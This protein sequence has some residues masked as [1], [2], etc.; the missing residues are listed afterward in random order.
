MKH[1]FTKQ[2]GVALIAVY[3][4]ICAAYGVFAQT[5]SSSKKSSPAAFSNIKLEYQV[6]M[7]DAGWLGWT[8]GGMMSG[9]LERDLKADALQVKLS[10]QPSGGVWYAVCTEDGVWQAWT[11]NGEVSGKQNQANIQAIALR[12][13]DMP[14]M[15]IEYRVHVTG[16]EWLAWTSNGEVAGSIGKGKTID[17]VEIRLQNN[18]APE[19]SLLG[20]NPPPTPGTASQ[21]VP[22]VVTSSKKKSSSAS[23]DAAS[24]QP[25]PAQGVESFTIKEPPPTPPTTTSK[26]TSAQ[27]S[28]AQQTQAQANQAQVAP[29]TSNQA[30]S[31]QQQGNQT[32]WGG[33]ANTAGQLAGQAMSGMNTGMANNNFNRNNTQFSQGNQ[34]NQA[35]NSQNWSEWTNQPMQ[36]V[37]GQGQSAEQP[38]FVPISSRRVALV[39]NNNRYLSAMND[40]RSDAL[41]VANRSGISDTEIFE[42]AFLGEHRVALKTVNGRYLSVRPMNAGSSTITPS[43]DIIGTNETF[44]MLGS[45]VNDRVTFRAF[46]GQFLSVEE[47]GQFRLFAKSGFAGAAESFSIFLPDGRPILSEGQ[48]QAGSWQSQRDANGRM[49]YLDGQGRTVETSDRVLLLVASPQNA[50]STQAMNT[51]S[52]TS[53]PTNALPTNTAP[54]NTTP[55]NSTATTPATPAAKP[56]V[57]PK[58]YLAPIELDVVQEINFVRTKPGEY[59]TLLEG[60]RK[61][62][63]GRTLSVPGQRPLSTKE[64]VKALDEAILALK[65][66][67]PVEQVSASQGLTKAARDHVDNT[68]PRGTLGHVGTDKSNPN[69]RAARYGTGVV[70]E[71]LCYGRSTARDVI[72]RLLIDDGIKDRG[73]RKNILNPAYK[74]VGTAFGLHKS[75]QTMCSQVFAANYEEK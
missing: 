11:R 50:A 64:G 4:S 1:F 16:G 35:P 19:A 70:N 66:M 27:Q 57:D 10:Q 63:K 49:M 22:Q 25:L 33:V 20:E 12:L 65:M 72:V 53:A 31:G 9:M 39:A 29:Q 8:E 14:N 37:Q 13:Y 45:N 30:Q 24:S 46:N 52:A 58:T 28:T 74:L 62:Y 44:E 56:V 3:M 6:S 18:A 68:G 7:R 67:R 40:P 47:V 55:A 2:I 17:G 71:N 21:A 41:F 36:R 60:Y 26:K 15:G 5:A 43:A 23:N 75:Q 69:D 61:F 32:D 42:L 59:A 54:A 73:Y 48:P 38:V 51:V 34:F